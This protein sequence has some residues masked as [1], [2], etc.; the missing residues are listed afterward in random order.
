MLTA[1]IISDFNTQTT[2]FLTNHM[3]KTSGLAAHNIS[4]TLQEE[5]QVWGAAADSNNGG[6]RKLQTQ[7][8]ESTTLLPLIA[9]INM[10]AM[11]RDDT[12]ENANDALIQTINTNSRA[13]V[14]ALR[15]T[16]SMSSNVYYGMVDTIQAAPVGATPSAPPAAAPTPAIEG[17]DTPAETKKKGLGGTVGLVMGLLLLSLLLAIIWWYC[18]IRRR[19]AQVLAA[20][21]AQV[22]SNSTTPNKF[23]H[24]Q[25]Y[26]D[27]PTSKH[28]SSSDASSSRRSSSGS[29]ESDSDEETNTTNEDS[30]DLKATAQRVA[31]A[32]RARAAAA[33]PH[34][35]DEDS[36]PDP[37]VDEDDDDDSSSND[38]GADTLPDDSSHELSAGRSFARAQMDAAAVTAAVAAADTGHDGGSYTYSVEADAPL[39]VS[40]EV[41]KREV[42]DED[43][44]IDDD[45]DDD[46]DDDETD[47]DLLARQ[48]NMV[49]R[50]VDA[51]PGKLGIVIDTTLEGP[52]VHKINSTSPLD[53]LLF[54][55]DIIVAIDD[56]DT[57]AMSASASTALMVKTANKRR[58]LRVI[59]ED[60]Q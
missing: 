15:S 39:G 9:T 7:A 17:G 38:P 31:S 45:V 51:P 46:E 14:A 58:K 33:P 49:A 29:P 12:V 27:E 44:D 11:T 16:D 6:R 24:P 21:A 35:S 59:S 4:V 34:E 32:Q 18:R 28:S 52:V 13:L 55:G 60:T 42:Q 10:Q 20:A 25:S 30:A 40:P 3:Y 2:Q 5:S 26:Y 53:G 41:L 36:E 48:E 43:D 56:V 54:P 22:R 50:D 1:R 23:S 19:R 57:R 47:D 8:P 37:G